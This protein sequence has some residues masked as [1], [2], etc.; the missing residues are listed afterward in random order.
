[1]AVCCWSVLTNLKSIEGWAE[2]QF[3]YSTHLQKLWQRGINEVVTLS[4]PV[5]SLVGWITRNTF[6]GGMSGN[7]VL[8]NWPVVDGNL[9]T[10]E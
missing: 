1:M 3:D 7:D 2:R 4:V 6:G 10:K 9:L 5:Y 8:V